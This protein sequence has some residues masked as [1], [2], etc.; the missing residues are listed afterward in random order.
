MGVYYGS[1]KALGDIIKRYKGVSSI[2]KVAMNKTIMDKSIMGKTLQAGRLTDTLMNK[3]PIIKPSDEN[4]SKDLSIDI[5][6]TLDKADNNNMVLTDA[7]E[8]G[9][10]PT[11]AITE[12]KENHVSEEAAFQRRLQEAVIWSEILDKPLSK[13][14]KRR[15]MNEGYIG[16]R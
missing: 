4:K 14:R 2:G 13:R 8:A 9:L 16:R 10:K 5:S 1:G 15:W 11:D 12:V 3:M 6:K 7:N